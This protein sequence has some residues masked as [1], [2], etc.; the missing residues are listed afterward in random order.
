M[1]ERPQTD[2]RRRLRHRDCR[3]RYIDDVKG[4]DKVRDPC[5]GLFLLVTYRIKPKEVFVLGSTPRI[6]V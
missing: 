2:Q 3:F 4:L 5:G 1:D 6:H